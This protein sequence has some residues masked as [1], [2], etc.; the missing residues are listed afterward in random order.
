MPEAHA[1]QPLV[2][3]PFLFSAPVSSTIPRACSVGLVTH[4]TDARQGPSLE[5]RWASP[6]YPVFGI[7]TR[8]RN[9][10]PSRGWRSAVQFATTL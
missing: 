5:R 2:G 1:A 10:I 7:R 3:E 6:F 8:T 4:W 9:A